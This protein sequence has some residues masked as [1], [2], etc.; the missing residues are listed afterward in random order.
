MNRAVIGLG[1]GDEGKGLVTDYLCSK[2]SNPLVVRFS[3][4]QQAGHTVY[5]DDKKTSHV[6]HTF[7]SGTLR[8]VPTFW[9]YPATV[10]PVSVKAE[11]EK[12]AKKTKRTPILWL[13]PKCPI[14]TPFDIYDNQNDQTLLQNGTCG[15]G[16]GNTIQREED[17]YSLTVLDLLYPKVLNLKLKAIEEHY[18]FN[19]YAYQVD[20]SYI[21]K[22]KKACEWLAVFAKIGAFQTTANLYPDKIFESSQ[23]LMLDQNIGFFP[24]VTRSNVGFKGLKNLG[25]SLSSLHVYYVTRAYQTRHGNGPMTNL[26]IP[27]DLKEDI[28]ETNINNKYQGEFRKS[29]LDLDLV[30]YAIE[31]QKQIES[32]PLFNLVITCLDHLN[33]YK[34]T[35]NNSLHTFKTEEEF[36]SFIVE[37]LN[38]QRRVFISHDPYS[39][40][41]QFN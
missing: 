23:G 5:T 8:G 39:T 41:K 29:V 12:L 18:Y 11:Y 16:V 14:T 2:T 24:N 6:F 10:D 32:S 35:Y 27:L 20:G 31:K 38:V 30:L 22:F 34:L 36:V 3:G 13:D 1:F 19:K 9:A 7:G 25:I 21:T 33:E 28:R 4:G 37:K 15:F 17:Y 40:L 26:D